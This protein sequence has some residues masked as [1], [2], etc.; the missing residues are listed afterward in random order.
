MDISKL[1]HGAKLV[2]GGTIAF[3]LLSFFSWFHYTGPGSDQAEALG[4][5]TGFSM[6]HGVGYLAGLFAIA[7]IVWQAIRPANIEL[8][9]GVTP[10]MV[11]AALAVLMALFAI[12]RF[13]DKPGGDF[14]GRT[15][16]AWLAIALA[17]AVLV[18]AWMNMKAA[19]EGLSDI[20]GSLAAG[21]GA[22]TAAAKSASAPKP[23]AAEPAA[24]AP[25]VRRRVGSWR[26][27]CRCHRGSGSRG[28][29]SGCGDGLR[30]GD[31]GGRRSL[32][33]GGSGRRCCR[34]FRARRCGRPASALSP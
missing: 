15:F 9:I 21:A 25:S 34:R 1:S 13:L 26:R 14:V 22:A 29:G 28:P 30:D 18:D 31:R 16:W 4:I 3:L 19:G 17:I 8:E 2:L 11:T 5:D 7:L 23:D 32:G 24:P 12:I 10:S 27:G 33:R 6:W 20:K